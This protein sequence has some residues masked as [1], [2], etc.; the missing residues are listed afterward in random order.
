MRVQ[1]LGARIHARMAID[2]AL[3]QAVALVDARFQSG[4]R[5]RDKRDQ[6][7]DGAY[8]AA[9]LFQKHHFEQQNRRER[10]KRPAGLV[11]VEQVPYADKRCEREPHRADE[12]KH[13]KA[14]HGRRDQRAREHRMARIDLHAIALAAD[15]RQRAAGA[16]ARASI[17]LSGV[18]CL[19]RVQRFHQVV[20]LFCN[21]VRIHVAALFGIA[22]FCGRY[23]LDARYLLA[24][25]GPSLGPQRSEFVNYGKE[26][27]PDFANWFNARDKTM[28]LWR[29]TRDQLLEAGLPDE[30]IFGL[31]LCTASMPDSF[32]S[33]R[34]DGICGRQ[35][36]VIWIA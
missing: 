9:P 36:N 7:R 3:A 11:E 31:D 33:Y 4:V 8:F 6:R 34:R 27:G 28:K 30:G 13:G 26:W 32:F 18:A 2:A 24:V 22:A 21:L 17:S 5:V 23:G 16:A 15:G 14:E 29:L 25:R 20:G 19:L 12:A 1:L 35:A 10:D